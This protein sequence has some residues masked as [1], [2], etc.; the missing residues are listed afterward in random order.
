[1]SEK[2]RFDL[3]PVVATPA[4]LELLRKNNSTGLE[5]LVRHALGDWGELCDE[6][7]QAN[8]AALHTGARLMSSY[9]LPDGEVLWIITDAEVDEEHR[10]QAT[11]LLRQ[12]DH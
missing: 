7:K 2:P 1:M 10:R 9:R 6:D 3:G 4:A 8:E 11:T 12:N 5:Y